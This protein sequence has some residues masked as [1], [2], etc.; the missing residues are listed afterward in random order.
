[1]SRQAQK[2]L[3]QEDV[4]TTAHTYVAMGKKLSIPPHM[5]WYRCVLEYRTLN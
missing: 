3:V 1:M 2:S 5:F 4:R